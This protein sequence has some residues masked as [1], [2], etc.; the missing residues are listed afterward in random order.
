MKD[1]GVH[2]VQGFFLHKPSG[3]PVTSSGPVITGQCGAILLPPRC[4]EDQKGLTASGD[5]DSD[6]HL[7]G[8]GGGI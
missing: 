4:L 5:Q 7:L 6:L 3:A 2:F 8:S 1:F